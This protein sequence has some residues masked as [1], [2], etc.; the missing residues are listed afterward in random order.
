MKSSLEVF[1]QSRY[2][3][4]VSTITTLDILSDLADVHDFIG[5]SNCL[6]ILI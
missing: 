2:N 3:T 4:N 5:Y 6:E 1:R